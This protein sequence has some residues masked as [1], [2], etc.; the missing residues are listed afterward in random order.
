MRVKLCKLSLMALCHWNTSVLS[1][2]VLH[3]HGISLT[4]SCS[5][6]N[7]IPGIPV[8]DKQADF[9]QVSDLHCTGINDLCLKGLVSTTAPTNQMAPSRSQERGKRLFCFSDY[10]VFAISCNLIPKVLHGK[11][12][13]Y[14][15]LFCCGFVLVFI[16]GVAFCFF[17]FHLLL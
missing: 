14:V 2:P 5:E 15:R 6:S 8:K 17:F 12:F 10:K 9:H 1:P 3:F 16:L 11:S 4:L 7:F 13:P